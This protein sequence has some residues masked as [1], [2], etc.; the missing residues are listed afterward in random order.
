MKRRAMVAAWLLL[1][2]VVTN[3][4]A[5]PA[6]V[7]QPEAS[8]TATAPGALVR[9]EPIPSI[10]GHPAWRILYTSTGLDGA[11]VPISG[12]IA[13]PAATAPQEGFP[14]LAIAH[15][16]AGLGRQCAP[17]LLLQNNASLMSQLY[18]EILTPYLDAGFALIMSDY[19]GLG[20]QGDPSYLIGAIEGRNLL[21]SVRAAR[22]LPDVSLSDS[23]QLIGHS[24]G[25]HA[26]AF[27]LQLAP[28]YA[29]EL[30]FDGAVLAAPALDPRGI[31]TSLIDGD[32]ASENTSLILF[33]MAAWSATYADASLDQ[34]T[35]P[36]GQ[37]VIETEIAGACLIEAGLAAAN[38]APSDLFLPDAPEAW[39]DLA[40][41]NTPAAGTW[42]MPVLIVHGVDDEVIDPAMT[43]SFVDGLCASGSTVAFIEYP[44]ADHFGILSAAGDTMRD[45]L[46]DR[47]AGEPAPSD[48]AQATVRGTAP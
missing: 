18:Q 45:W 8:P 2:T 14:L 24:Q 11:I 32:V 36:L 3:G 1:L 29:P 31:F 15:P 9:W 43:A 21:D 10:G 46:L 47:V 34:V 5:G 12:V 19:Q 23:T 35:T 17:S 42:P 16:T 40:A 26:A 38:H 37:E 27:A 39:S 25:G 4:I 28:D 20:M 13:I 30:T 44:G 22:A 41:E 33:V 6:A 7:A 48:C